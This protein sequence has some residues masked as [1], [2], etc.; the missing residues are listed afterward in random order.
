MIEINHFPFDWPYV[1]LSLCAILCVVLAGIALWPRPPERSPPILTADDVRRII[2]EE[3]K[4]TQKVGC[5][6][7]ELKD[8]RGYCGN[9]GYH[10][11]EH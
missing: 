11:S 10:H 4:A 7:F 3:L 8:S 9:C 1:V 2:R 6:H 5:K